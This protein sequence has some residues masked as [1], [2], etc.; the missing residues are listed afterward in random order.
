VAGG[1]QD[2][3]PCRGHVSEAAHGRWWVPLAAKF[4]LGMHHPHSNFAAL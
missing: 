1:S 2:F 4:T 3:E